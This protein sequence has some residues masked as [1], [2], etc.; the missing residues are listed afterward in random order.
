MYIQENNLQKQCQS[1]SALPK[2]DELQINLM[3]WE[4][5]KELRRRQLSSTWAAPS[6]WDTP[7]LKK[8]SLI[9]RGPCTY[10][11][12]HQ[13]IAYRCDFFIKLGMAI[14]P[15]RPFVSFDFGQNWAKFRIF[16]QVRNYFCSNK[17]CANEICA[18]EVSPFFVCVFNGRK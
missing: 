7:F 13:V 4:V 18:N 9:F 2:H 16:A 10:F 14:K 1:L 6:F 15:W 11:F 8:T 12:L 5:R 17:V 3:Y